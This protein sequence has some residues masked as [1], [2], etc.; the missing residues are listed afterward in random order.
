MDDLTEALVLLASNATHGCRPIPDPLDDVFRR[1]V[2]DAVAAAPNDR[3]QV[4]AP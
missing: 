2:H 1:L 4:S 3:R